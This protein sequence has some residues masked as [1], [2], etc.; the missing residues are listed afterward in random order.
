[1]KSK[2]CQGQIIIGLGFYF[3]KLVYFFRKLYSNLSQ[4][5]FFK[6]I[7]VSLNDKYYGYTKI[8]FIIKYSKNKIYDF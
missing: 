6:I 5:F 4:T 2:K 1:M 3:S 7:I 8:I